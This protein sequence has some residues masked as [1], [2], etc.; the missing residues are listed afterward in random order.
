MHLIGESRLFLTSSNESP[1][2]AY[3]KEKVGLNHIASGARA[4]DE[5]QATQGQLDSG[6]I[7]HSG[8]QK[9]HYGQKDFVRWDHPDGMRVELH[10][11]VL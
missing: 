6:A 3:N 8:I 9:E 4:L 10:L 11:R 1:N 2:T 7:S 5:L